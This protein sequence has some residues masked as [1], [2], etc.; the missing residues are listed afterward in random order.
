MHLIEPGLKLLPAHMDTP[1]ARVMLIAIGLQESG[2]AE[3]VQR[4]LRPGKPPGPARGLWQFERA[5]G[6][7]GVLTHRAT[8]ELA[9]EI[10]AGR[11]LMTNSH[12]V[13]GALATDDALA[14]AF[15]RLLLFTDPKP[16]PALGAQA[17][18]W[19]YYLRNWRPGKP[20]AER[21]PKNY[22]TAL[23]ATR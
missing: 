8:S 12:A 22:A 5:G 15:A 14:G 4:S 18:A 10:V 19:D 9:H 20:H 23:E 6:V 2:L 3:R 17:A 1:E 16:L 7:S 21:W 11:G 13:W